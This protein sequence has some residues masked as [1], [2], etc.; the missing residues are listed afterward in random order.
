MGD[1]ADLIEVLEYLVPIREKTL[2]ASEMH[3]PSQAG[4]I[5]VKQILRLMQH[6]LLPCR[7]LFRCQDE[8]IMERSR[9]KYPGRACRSS[10]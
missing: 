10:D 9:A 4:Q 2:T 8:Y 6:I 1:F 7:G 3:D 5:D